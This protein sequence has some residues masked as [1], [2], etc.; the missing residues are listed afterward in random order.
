MSNPPHPLPPEGGRQHGRSD[1]PEHRGGPAPSQEVLRDLMGLLALPALWAGRDGETILELMTQAVERIVPLTVSCVQVPILPSQLPTRVLRVNG[2]TLDDAQTLAWEPFVQACNGMAHHTD[3]SMLQ[4]T[5]LGPLRVIRLYLGSGSRGGSI[6]FASRDEGFPSLAHGAVLRAAVSLA[7]TGLHTA[8]LNHEREQAS[9]AKDEFLAMLGHEL[10]NP[11]APIV[12]ALQLMRRRS[13][14]PP[15][16]EQE[17]IERQVS[18]LTR[19]VDDLMDVTRITRGR[20]ELQPQAVEMQAVL[21]EAFESVSPLIEQRRHQ[22]ALEAP[23][24]PAR[25]MGD[26]AR[27]RQVFVNLLTNAAKYTD[28]GGQIGVRLTCSSH[29]VEVAIQDNGIGIEPKLLPLVFN[30]FEQGTT[31]IERSR[32]GLGIGLAIVRNLVDLHHGSVTVRSDGTGCGSTFTVRLPLHEDVAP[33]LPADSPVIEAARSGRRLRLMLVDDNADAVQLM[34]DAL[35]AHGFEV[36][37]APDPVEALKLSAGFD[38]DVAILDI[39]LPVMDGYELA[40]KLRQVSG[41]SDK[42]RLIA[43]TGYGQPKDRARATAAGFQTHFVKPVHTAALVA[44]IEALCP[45][46][47]PPAPTG[48]RRR[49]LP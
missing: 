1:V 3:K 39:G 31:T 10:R 41:V 4:D 42:P 46:R 25:V 40:H 30:L 8:R 26:P 20:V 45:P 5:P 15:S 35:V 18:H 22:L 43:L 14:Q 11:L 38:P 16:R 49:E 47:Q 32:G 7:T 6:W 12:T 33:P 9:R 17:I 48:A 28:A 34:H 19:L 24:T 37:T 23:Q 13:D 21:A 44:A 2:R 29:A 27:L 36:V